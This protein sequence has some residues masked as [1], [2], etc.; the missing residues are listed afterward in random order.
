MKKIPI[1]RRYD[2]MLGADPQAD[3]EAELSF[4]YEM[5]VRDYM[6][7]GMDEASARLAA[8]ER[9][10]DLAKVRELCADEGDRSMNTMQRR[11]WLDELKQDL[12]YGVRMLVRSPLFAVLA[13]VMLGLGIGA[14]TAMFSVVDRVLLSA[15]PYPQPERLV[16]VWERSPQGD[17]RN[18]VSPGN[19][20]EWSSRTKSFREIGAHTQTFE[21][22]FT[23][24]GEPGRL[25][26]ADMTPSAFRALGVAPLIGRGFI[27]DDAVAGNRVV[28]LSYGFWQSRFGSR[29]D[30]LNERIVLDDI[31]FTVIG[32]MPP[33]FDF[34]GGG[35][36]VWRSLPLD[37]FNPNERRSH[38]Y[39]VV[40]RLAD[41][42]P[43]ERAQ[44]ELSALAAA[45]AQEHPQFMQGWGTNVVPL[46]DDLTADVRPLLWILFG[47]VGVVLLIACGN[48][49]NLLLARAI[50][51]EREIAVRGALGA[52]RAR[53][54]R[55]LLTENLLIGVGGGV[56]GLLVASVLLRVLIAKAPDSIPLLQGT[57]LNWRV[58][59]FSC[60]LTIVSTLV[61]GLM[62]ALRL[63]RADLQQSL[64]S[65]RESGSARDSRIRSALLVAEVA[66]SVVLLVAAGVLTRSFV[67][68][69]RVDLGYESRGLILMRVDLPRA[70]YSEIPQQVEMH[71]RLV[72]RVASIPGVISAAGT[73]H[74]PASFERMTF[75]F[76]IEGRQAANPSGREDPVPLHTITSNYFRTF[77]IDVEEGRAFD[78]RDGADGAPVVIINRALARKHWPNEN[79]VGKR[80]RFGR[81][82]AGWL[83]IVG[84]VSDTRMESPDQDPEP[85]LY[86][87]NAQKVW[88][89]LTWFGV[90][91]RVPSGDAQQWLPQFRAALWELDAQI[92]L[93]QVTD[94]E[95][96][97]GASIA[98]RSF[99][100]LLVLCFAGFAL[101]LSLVGLYGLMA[102]TV[103]QQ[104]QEIGV[105]L[106]LGARGIDVLRT[107]LGR[108]VR[109]ALIGLAIGI[110][111][112]LFTTQLLGTLLYGV[113]PNDPLTL[114]GI[115]LLVLLTA[116]AAA[117][118]PAWRA[119]RTSPLAALRG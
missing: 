42:V 80:I 37:A 87:P 79:A 9:L 71:S 10:G 113:A 34:P 51:R 7:A 22:V 2:R 114:A 6:R 33:S 20:L 12:R 5:R 53:V 108:S 91:A 1:W 14:T 86:I 88:P 64:R 70:R 8:R 21:M 56:A 98:R 81:G 58:L 59:V 52:G 110:V 90:I 119:L 63:A 35:A 65:R 118:V 73:S 82:E 95:T 28:L 50:A 84:V 85:A 13:M 16:R 115:A 112:A 89:W 66:L 102:Y 31:G 74:A 45:L 11:E 105:R 17:E 96:L 69:Q 38:N 48:L 60:V 77:G 61:F 116:L 3:T 40:A 101:G 49:A 104:K 92:P 67:E 23:G 83:E 72:E 68:L 24:A 47:S 36:Q 78:S 29:Q 46:H 93:E 4:H 19:Y 103:A 76:E 62:P 26:I 75:S 43:I 111:I 30:V 97:Y 100:M 27:A 94:V 99:A 44:A 15:L 39:N 107:V 25:T 54:A 117:S 18:A 55:Q 32:V 106:A 57:Q 109:L 41:G